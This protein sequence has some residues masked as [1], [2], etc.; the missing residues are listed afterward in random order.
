MPSSENG[1]GGEDSEDEEEEEDVLQDLRLSDDEEG[2][3]DEEDAGDRGGGRGREWGVGVRTPRSV[4][5]FAAVDQTCF[6]HTKTEYTIV[7]FGVF[8]CNHVSVFFSS[9]VLV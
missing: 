9:I 1:T 2:E 8:S 6:E 3:E 5:S 7:F 4:L